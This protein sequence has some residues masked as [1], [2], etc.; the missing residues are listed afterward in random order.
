MRGFGRDPFDRSTQEQEDGVMK[1]W[2]QLA[3]VATAVLSLSSGYHAADASSAPPP[4]PVGGAQPHM[5]AALGALNT[6]LAELKLAEHDKG[7]WR[8]AAQEHTRHAIAETE[9]GI[10]FA[11]KH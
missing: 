4:A 10:A 3:L 8:A 1:M 9:R 6:A 5:A 7:G 11:D 2:K